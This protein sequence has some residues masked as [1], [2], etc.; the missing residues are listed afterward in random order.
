T[1]IPE[2]PA[3]KSTASQAAPYARRPIRRQR[4]RT[5]RS[6]RRLLRKHL[7]FRGQQRTVRL[8]PCR[9]SAQRRQHVG[10]RRD[11]CEPGERVQVDAFVLTAEEKEQHG[12]TPV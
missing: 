7:G 6:L 11:E 5:R 12:R 8:L 2:A 4:R 9:R 1:R 10:F 3:P